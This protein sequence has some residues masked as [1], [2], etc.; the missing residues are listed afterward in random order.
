MR[1]TTTARTDSKT[2][3]TIPSDFLHLAGLGGEIRLDLQPGVA[4]LTGPATAQGKVDAMTALLRTV[5]E[6]ME[7]LIAECGGVPSDAVP[8]E[9]CADCCGCCAGEDEPFF[10]DCEGCGHRG[11]CDEK[12]S[13]PLCWLEDAGIPFF[14]G[15]CTVCDDGKIVITAAKD[16][17]PEEAGEEP[18]VDAGE[19]EHL[20]TLLELNGIDPDRA[21]A[22]LDIA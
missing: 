3:I 11:I 21:R 18:G 17:E 4:V 1:F 7:E 16:A 8:G 15:L 2:P 19:A 6:M 20:L 9:T 10:E 22:L 14:D 12:V 13:L 5:N